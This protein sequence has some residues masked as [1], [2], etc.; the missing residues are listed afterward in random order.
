[1]GGKID[2]IG[3]IQ[4]QQSYGGSGSDQSY[5]I[6]QTTDGGYIIAGISSS[7]DVDVSSNNGCFD[8]WIVK[9]NNSGIIQWQNSY[10]GSGCEYVS[11]IQQTNDGG[12]IVGGWTGSNDGD[13]TENYGEY[14]YWIVK[15]DSSGIMQWQQ[16][17]GALHDDQSNSIQQTTDG[18]YIV[19]GV[20]FITADDDEGNYWILKL[21]S[22]GV[23]Q[24]QKLLAVQLMMGPIP[25]NKQRM[26]AILL[27]EDRIQPMAT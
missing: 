3:N 27:L 20:S 1:M 12:Y 7:N 15:L 5:A 6:Q 9:L 22:F 16:S 8:Y 14:D 13:V 24:W 25:S 21:D 10:G 18:G 19:A 4:W 26:V 2:I 17:F 23:L 11:S